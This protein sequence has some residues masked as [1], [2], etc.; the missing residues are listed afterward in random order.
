MWPTSDGPPGTDLQMQGKVVEQLI[1]RKYV[2]QKS[3]A[4]PQKQ[5][6]QL[7]AGMAGLWKWLKNKVSAEWNRT[8]NLLIKSRS[9]FRQD[10]RRTHFIKSATCHNLSP[11]GSTFEKYRK[12]PY[13]R[14]VARSVRHTYGTPHIGRVGSLRSLPSASERTIKIHERLQ[15]G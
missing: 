3:V 11:H 8:F 9:G 2:M 10:F 12:S 4:Q 7:I 6:Q 15:F 13:W 1:Q 5:P 14:I